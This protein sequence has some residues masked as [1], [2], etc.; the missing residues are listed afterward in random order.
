MKEKIEEIINLKGK[1]QYITCFVIIMTA[2]LTTVYTLEISYLSKQPNFIEPLNPNITIKYSPNLCKD[3]E[4]N[5]LIKDIKNSL[6]NWS[7]SFNIYC[8]NDIY[9]DLIPTLVFAG[10][11]LGCLFLTQFPDRIGREKMLKIMMS[12]SLFV[13][14]LQFINSSILETLLI[15]LLGGIDTFTFSMSFY[16]VTEYLPRDWT[17]F[18]MGLLNGLY[19]LLGILLGFFFMFINKWRIIFT[20]LLILH[21]ITTYLIFAY[22]TESPNYL[23]NIGNGNHALECYKKIARINGREKEINE[24][25]EKNNKEIQDFFKESFQISSS[26]KLNFKTYSVIEIFQLKSQRKN[27]LILSYIWFAGSFNYFGIIINLKTIPGNFFSNSIMA[28]LGELISELTA[29]YISDIYGRLIIMKICSYFGSISFLISLFLNGFLK[30]TFIMIGMLGI[31]GCY[32]VSS[33]YTPEIF[34][35]KLRGTVCGFLCLLMR[36]G[37]LCVPTLTNFLGIGVYFLMVISELFVGIL[38][39]FL[40]ET[41]NRKIVDSIPEENERNDKES[42]LGNYYN[43]ISSFKSGDYFNKEKNEKIEVIESCYLSGNFNSF[44]VK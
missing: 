24:Y 43:G 25:I 40:E 18:S 31:A 32:T 22:F 38:V 9:I 6:N 4:S 19:S 39:N 3:I 8:S 20:V 5:K 11:L 14:F 35:P 16:V 15:N 28:F 42:F 12:F 44:V 37:P 23:I 13:M 36:V 30:S 21:I 26:K 27:F 41:L 33:V 10:A 7:Y 2:T 29:G 1:F 17:G 34:A